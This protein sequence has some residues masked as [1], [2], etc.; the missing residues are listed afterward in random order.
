[1]GLL[2]GNAGAVVER[3]DDDKNFMPSKG[4]LG[5]RKSLWQKNNRNDHRIISKSY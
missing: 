4:V 2:Y 3:D 1:M 5:V